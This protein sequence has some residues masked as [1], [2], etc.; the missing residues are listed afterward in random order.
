M[1]PLDALHLPLHGQILIEASAGT[2]KTFT[3]GLFYLRLLLEQGFSVDQILVVTF[4]RA[5]TEELRDRIRRRIRQALDV[6]AGNAAVD[7]VLQQLM[8]RI[9]DTNQAAITLNDALTR[10]DEAVIFTIHSFCQRMLQDYAFESGAPF[11]MEFLETEKTLRCQVMEDFWR[12]HLYNASPAKAAWA[13]SLWETPGDLLQDLGGH[14]ERHDVCCLPVIQQ[15]TLDRQQARLQTLFTQVQTVWQQEKDTLV[16]II[17]AY[18]EQGVISRDK[19]KGYTKERF[20]LALQAMERLAR[21]D[22]MPWILPDIL[23]LLTMD[24]IC[25][26]LNKRKKPPPPSHPFFQLFGEFL[27][28]LDQMALNQKICFLLEGRCFLRKELS[29]RKKE[30]ALLYFDD[31]LTGLDASL[32]GLG[33]SSLARRIAGQFPVIMVDEFQDTDPLQY[34]IFRTIFRAG[35]RATLLLIG[36]PKQA[37]YGFRGAD[38]FTYFKARQDTPPDQRLTMDTN[39][40][41]ASGMVAMVNRLFARAN[42]FYL[43]AEIIGFNPV[44]PCPTADAT[45][46]LVQ[47]KNLPALQCLL[48]HEQEDTRS[49]AISKKEAGRLAADHCARQIMALLNLAA[50]GEAVIGDSP[51]MAGDMAVLVRTHAEAETMRSALSE[52]GISSVSYSRCSVFASDEARHLQ[53]VLTAL[54][55][56]TD[57]SLVRAALASDLFGCTAEDF[58]QLRQDETRWEEYMTAM[59]RYGQIW[60]QRGLAAV[61][62]EIMTEQQLVARLSGWQ[63]GERRLTNYLHLVE[64]LQEASR[65][66]TGPE[67]L[68]RWLADQM[69]EPDGD[70]SSQQLRLESDEHLVKIVT[71]HK[72]KGLEYPVVFLPFPWSARACKATDTLTFHA[73][74]DPERLCLDLGSGEQ[75]SLERAETE[76]RAEDL[77]LLYVALTRARHCCY[78]CWGRI[79]LME[80][81]A[82]CYLLH[83]GRCPVDQAALLADLGRISTPQNA[84]AVICL[85]DL[86]NGKMNR[87]PVDEAVSPCRA[88]EFTGQIDSRWQITSYSRLTSHSSSHPE[89]P[90]YDQM[91]AS[92]GES[93]G[94][95]V[96]AFPR[97]PAAGTCLHA[98]LEKIDF[99]DAS[100]H[101]QIIRSQ[102]DLAGIDQSWQAVVQSWLQRILTTVLHDDCTLAILQDSDKITEMSFYFPLRPLVIHRLNRVLADFGI[103]PLPGGQKEIVGLMV[104]FIDLV[105]RYQ[106]R[107]YVAD[108]KSNHLGNGPARY[109]PDNLRQAILEHRYDLQYLIYTLALH[110]F[111][112]R[113]IAAYSYEEHMGGVAYLF[114]RGMDPAHGTGSGVFRDVPPFA[115]IDGLDQCCDGGGS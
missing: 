86:V 34:R 33:G 30:Q 53:W 14:L 69:Q 43:D 7:D 44:K 58:E 16:A 38:I 32:T 29:R 26:S 105:Y 15:Q 84:L 40:R 56:L 42:P 97:G 114:L 55:N 48:L 37:I 106:G 71:I 81:S 31:L 92:A 4:T 110:R 95:D 9:Q 68:L 67:M 99:G 112:G 49:K 24:T 72:A 57:S 52:V 98:I 79:A 75:T 28:D 83:D 18:M 22:D 46:L 2:G 21:C 94:K 20:S 102:L 25:S 89:L 93:T 70:A 65:G 76:H 8:T 109:G 101:E 50:R 103:A 17:T 108:Y 11:A 90:D 47:G 5:A 61:L 111:L 77:R 82:L 62:Y 113:R 19:K 12:I 85:D 88:R 59:A 115:L 63:D 91:A 23:K 96:F 60:Q 1:Q 104:G 80:Q 6:L 10:M 45:P 39:Y 35:H 64:L 51:L 73:A 13:R 36:D 74:D 87:Q 27:T 107:Y 78:F 66:L 100:G 54:C 3:I 41:S